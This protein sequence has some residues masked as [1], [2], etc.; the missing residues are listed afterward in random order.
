MLF[1]TF[2]LAIKWILL[3]QVKAAVMIGILFLFSFFVAG[4]GIAIVVESIAIQIKP[5]LCMMH[6]MLNLNQLEFQLV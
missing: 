4:F 3:F 5:V 2:M 1:N 6:S